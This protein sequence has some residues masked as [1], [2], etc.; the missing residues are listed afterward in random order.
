MKLIQ[1]IPLLYGK[2]VALVVSSTWKKKNIF[3]KNVLFPFG[4]LSYLQY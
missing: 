3:Q 1:I 4:D 2:F